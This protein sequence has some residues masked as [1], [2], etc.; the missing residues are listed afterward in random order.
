VGELPSVRTMVRTM[1]EESEWTPSEE[2]IAWTKEHLL[3]IGVDGVWSPENCGVTYVRQDEN[4]FALMRMVDHPSAVKHHANFKKLFEACGIELLEGDGAVL[5]PPPL[6]AEEGAQQRFEEKQQIARGWKCE[7]GTP[8]AN[9]DLSKRVDKYIENKEI[10]LSN[11][12]TTMVELWCCDITCPNCDTVVSMDPDD[13]NLLAGDDLF[14]TW[15]DSQGGEHV[16]LTRMQI[17]E[18]ADAGIDGTVLG[19]KSPNTGDPVPPWMW[20]TYTLYRLPEII[21]KA[22]EEE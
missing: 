17:K 4:T 12:D 8:L 7:C 15:F 22:D 13:Y 6:N 14:M 18:L 10:L 1:S 21:E 20:G 19:S 9:F 16:A 3:H 11:G 5:V 2:D